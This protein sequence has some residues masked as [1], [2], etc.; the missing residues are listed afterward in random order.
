[1]VN[2]ID[3]SPTGNSERKWADVETELAMGDRK[4]YNGAT[5]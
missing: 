2:S 1:M 5:R 4:F 3:S